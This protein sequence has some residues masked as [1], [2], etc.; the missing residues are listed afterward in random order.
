MNILKSRA[1]VVDDDDDC[2]C[3]YTKIATLRLILPIQL[4]LK[5][6]SFL[7]FNVHGLTL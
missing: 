3:R 4:N 7:A 1:V 2:I 5:N 6:G